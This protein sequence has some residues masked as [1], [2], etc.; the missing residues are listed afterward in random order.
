MAS[1]TFLTFP[2]CLLFC[3]VSL[4]VSGKIVL[5]DGYTVTTVFDGNKLQ[6]NPHAVLQLPGSSDLLILDTFNSAFY[7]VQFPI[8]QDSV[9]KRFSGSGQGFSDG[10]VGSAQFRKP[11]SFAA[12]LNGN[13]Y[14]ADRSNHAIRKIS[15]SGVTTIAGG[16]SHKEGK[17]DGPAQNATFSNDFELAFVPSGCLLLVSDHGNQLVRQINLKKGDCTPPQSGLGA[18]PAWALGLGFGLLFLGVIYFVAVRPCINS[19]KGSRAILNTATWKRC[20]INL[21]KIVVIHCFAVKSASVSSIISSLVSFLK[22]LWSLSVS[23]LFLMFRINRVASPRPCNEHRPLIDL[24]SCS[25]EVTEPSKYE[26]QLRDLVSADCAGADNLKMDDDVGF[27]ETPKD[28][29]LLQGSSVCNY[30]LVKRK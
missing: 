1:S 8:S 2:P 24:D 23:H 15:R 17:E 14:V 6:V 25:C 9:V 4:H 16:I 7:T 5:E 18:V 29:V 21:G 11:N 22:K 12:D 30:G 13:V 3:I 27:A 28:R 10:D 20:L 19:R 26:D